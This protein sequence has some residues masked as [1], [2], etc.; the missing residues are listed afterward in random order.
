MKNS[1]ANVVQRVVA[2]QVH[3]FRVLVERYQDAVYRFV[4][5]LVSHRHAAEDITQ[6]VFFAAYMHLASFDS[7]RAMFST[8]LFTI[9]RNRAINHLK[10][11]EHL[12]RLACL[13]EPVDMEPPR[14]S[15]G[16]G[17]LMEQLDQALSALPAHQKTVFVLAE[18][19]GVPHAEIAEIEQISM[20]TV[21]SRLH[22]AKQRLRVL[23]ATLVSE[24]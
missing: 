16:G 21:K 9:A 18:I 6:D 20:G 11:S 22:R 19:E 23:L 14:E 4:Y 5:G 13:P 24:R 8:W 10:H 7:R 2:G 3:E 1:D 15:L 17:D 12:S